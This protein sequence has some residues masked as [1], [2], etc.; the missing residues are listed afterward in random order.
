M[1]GASP[2]SSA[3]W[4]ALPRSYQKA[5]VTCLEEV[6]DS[7]SYPRNEVRGGIKLSVQ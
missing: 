2:E 5:R 7:L 6:R 3:T 4:A 1:A